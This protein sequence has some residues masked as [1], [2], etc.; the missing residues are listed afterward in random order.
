MAKINWLK[1][2]QDYIS[3]PSM[4]CEKIAVKYGVSVDAVND[5]CQK[6]NWQK[7]RK[8]VT[9]KTAEKLPDKI[10]ESA[11]QYQARKFAQGKQVADKA[12]NILMNEN[13]KIGSKTANEMLTTGHKLQTEAMGLD[14]PKTQINVS[15]TF[16][17][18][19]DFFEKLSAKAKERGIVVDGQVVET[20]T[21]RPD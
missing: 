14:N 18:L 5:W 4:T 6:L 15:N 10:A 21:S 1:A 19:E 13:T 2:Q 12:V 8:E 17:T 7:Q 11:A 3:D 9:E 20:S 16:I